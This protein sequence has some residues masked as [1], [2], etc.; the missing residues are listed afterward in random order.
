MSVDVD[1]W[2]SLLRFYSIAHDP[3]EVDLQVNVVNGI[4]KL[5]HLF[6][7]HDVKA[8]FFVSGEMAKKYA[9]AIRTII[10]DGHEIACH[11]LYHERNEYL[12]RREEQR[13]TIEEATNIIE[14]LTGRKPLGFRAPCLRANK[15]TLDL[16][17]EKGY[18]YDSSFLPMFLPGYYGSLSF[19]FKPYFPSSKHSGILEIPI[20][21]N[22]IIPLPFSGSWMRNLGLTWVEFGIKMLFNMKSS[23]MIYIHPR[24]VLD[25][26]LMPRVPWHVYR[27]TGNCCLKMLDELLSF[28][29]KIGGRITRAVDLALAAKNS[30]SITKC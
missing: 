19:K 5:L 26:P 14:N 27:N 3:S 16:L 30:V 29:N 1:G 13:A 25:L 22:P 11:G 9:D 24:D 28:V 8:T 7:E 6:K 15:T 21:T 4:E 10:H 20:S 23:V 12:L 18:L 2:S 17:N